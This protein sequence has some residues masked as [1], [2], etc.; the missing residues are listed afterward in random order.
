MK[1]LIVLIICILPIVALTQNIIISGRVVSATTQHGLYG[2]SILLEGKRI[3][4]SD[5]YGQFN[6]TV[7]ERDSILTI[8]FMEYKTYSMPIFKGKTKGYYVQLENDVQMMEEVIVSTGI[9]QLPKERATGSFEKID[10]QLFERVVVPNVLQRL[11]GI[12]TSLYYTKLPGGDEINIRGVSTIT[13][14][15]KPLIVVDNFPYDGDINNINANDIESITV[16][17]DA[18]AASIWGARSGNG[19]IVI[20]MKK[21]RFN[22]PMK[23]HLNTSISFQGKPRLMEN[24]QYIKGV[25]YAEVETFLFEKGYYN[26]DLNNTVSRPV[27]SPVVE[28]LAK[29][30]SG[31]LSSEQAASAIA[32]ITQYDI[33]QEMLQ[34]LNRLGVAQQFSIGMAGGSNGINYNFNLGY[35]GNATNVIGNNNERLTLSNNTSVKVSQK[36]EL[37]LGMNYTL[38]SFDQNAVTRLDAGKRSLL[39]YARLVDDNGKALAIEKDFRSAFL[40]TVGGGRLHDWKFRPL[41]E[42]KNANNRLNTQDILLRLG[43][44]YNINSAFSLE[45]NS[46]ME[47]AHNNQRNY[48]NRETYLVRDLSNRFTQLSSTTV[49]NVIPLGGILDLSDSRLNSYAGRVQVNFDKQWKLHQVNALAGGELRSNLFDLSGS[50]TYGFNEDNLNFVVMDYLTEFP[51]FMGLTS[52]MRIPSGSFQFNKTKNRL[53]SAFANAGYYFKERYSLTA[54]VRKDASNLF[55]VASNDKWSPFWSVGAGWEISKEAFYK[56]SALPYLKARVTYGYNGNINNGIASIPTIELMA[57]NTQVTDLPW[58]IV[59]NLS[60]SKLRWE[61]SGILNAGIDFRL[62]DQRLNGLI[63]L[64]KKNSIDLIAPS[65]VDPTSGIFVMN[66]NDASIRTNGLD[67]RLNA[68]II[69]RKIKLKTSLLYSHVKNVITKYSTVSPNKSTYINLTNSIKPREGADPYAITSYRFA[70]LDTAGNPIGYF[71]GNISKAYADIVNKPTWDDLVTTG[72]ARPT[73]FGNILNTI[74]YK[75]FS[76]SFNISY[77]LGYY[78]RRSTIHYANLFSS[79]VVHA[80]YYKRWQQK[81]D[82]AFTT[83]PSLIYPSN[84]NR[85]NF[86]ANSEANVSKGDHIRLQ[87]ISINYNFSGN[88]KG[89]SILKRLELYCY[90]S[91]LGILWRANRYGLDPEYPTTFPASIMC[92]FGLRKTF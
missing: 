78:F 8:L 29:K 12:T 16:L 31:Q 71:E 18:A 79:G 24:Q 58:A 64:Y 84:S 59:R 67:V 50:R 19:V 74:S 5:N 11:D 48:Y 44:K 47:K 76:I 27:I 54:S 83:V 81:G 73:T 41:D 68:L 66:L 10:Q 89:G 37:K 49:K 87:D 25:D 72:S 3:G 17:K 57:S 40:D 91:N 42:L 21:G 39:P 2:A 62:N 65:L 56:F 1:Y 77:K 20:T 51:I 14:G 6:V 85:D 4:L 23:V 70:G 33:R 55:G 92:S 7:N 9:Q 45:I 36:I 88:F 90:A 69:N 38:Q 75:E 60:N 35:D 86:Y 26:N 22:Q 13:A 15:T 34:Y 80:D 61:Q 28:I 52:A 53:A 30:R 46:Q 43:L 32:S 82:E 63:E